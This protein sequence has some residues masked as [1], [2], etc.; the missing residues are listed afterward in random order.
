MLTKNNKLSQLF[1]NLSSN[2][3]TCSLEELNALIQHVSTS[4]FINDLIEVD[5]ALW[6]SFWQFDVIAPGYLLPADELALLR[7]V[8]LDKNWPIGTTFEAYLLDLQRAITHPHSGIWSLTLA[9]YLCIIFAS[10]PSSGLSTIVW[11]CPSTGRIHAGYRAPTN[12]INLQHGIAQRPMSNL[13]NEINYATFAMDWL[14]PTI[15]YK[16]ELSSPSK[17]DYL[18]LAILEVRAGHL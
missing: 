11:Y 17:I 18:D 7:A 6:G 2:L 13:N 4:I 9:G 8:Q 12:Y 3:H 5:Q 14:Q 10:P 15:E 1:K 16:R